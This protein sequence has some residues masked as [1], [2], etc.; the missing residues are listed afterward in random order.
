MSQNH[1]PSCPV[2]GRGFPWERVET[3]FDT[4]SRW[5]GGSVVLD[6]RGVV[7]LSGKNR[8][9]SCEETLD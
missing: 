1:N 8:S 2:G 9:G 3:F 7:F 6:G 5:H 4:L